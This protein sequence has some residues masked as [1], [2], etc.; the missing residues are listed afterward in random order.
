MPSNIKVAIVGAGKVGRTLGRLA[1]AAG[2][3]IGT[4]ACRTAAHAEE[5]ARFIGSGRPTTSPE[6]AELTLLTV[7]DGEISAIARSL[8][9]PVG[10][11]VAHACASQ[12]V[13]AVRPHRP[14]GAIHPL[15]SFADPGGAAARFA[16]TACAVD[17]DPEAVEVL[18]EF[19]RAIGGHPFQVRTDRK[20]LYH[21]GAVLASNALVALLEGA[22]RLFEEAGVD[23]AAALGP[24]ASLS[25]GTLANV[26][27][28]GI[29]AALTGPVERGDAATVRRHVEA[30]AD[31]APKL[32]EAYAALG[33]LT[34]EVA[35]AKGSIDGKAADALRSAL[36]ESGTRK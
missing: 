30:L 28:V 31:G 19:A 23:R 35:E 10:A 34:V 20:P 16:G 22:L 4:V 7:P 15:R 11:V 32:A 21:A 36:G 1:R 5:A 29:P 9:V 8:R 12:G 3:E 13:E 27:S 26:R 14:G 18:E 17:G 6:G 2:Y 24:L 25:E 33:R